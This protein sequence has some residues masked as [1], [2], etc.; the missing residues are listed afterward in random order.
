[1]IDYQQCAEMDPMRA[2]AHVPH[3]VYTA[4]RYLHAFFL[5][6]STGVMSQES[7]HVSRNGTQA[8]A[9]AWIRK[10]SG[11][12]RGWT[13]R[14]RWRWQYSF[15]GKACIFFVYE[16]Q[17][18]AEACRYLSETCGR[19]PWCRHPWLSMVYSKQYA[20]AEPR[21]ASAEA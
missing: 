7:C 18:F 20:G 15:V 19:C 12:D 14:W 4:F 6:V 16:F 3:A 9:Q 11:T 13:S 21:F 8:G 5:C 17:S 2:Q 10:T 1:M